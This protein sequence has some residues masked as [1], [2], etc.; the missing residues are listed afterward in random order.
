M[1]SVILPVYNGAKYIQKAIESIISQTYTDWELIIVNDGSTDCTTEKIDA[2]RD[3][4]E[5]VCV[6]NNFNVGVT[7]S[8]NIALKYVSGDYIALQNADDTS[9]PRRFEEQLKL[10]KDNVGIVTTYSTAMN[11]KS[12][13]IADWYTDQAQRSSKDEILKSRK[14]WWVCGPSMMYTKEAIKRIGGYNEK[15]VI[16][17]DYNLWLRIIKHYDFDIVRKELYRFRRHKGSVRTMTKDK[18]PD[19]TQIA[20]DNV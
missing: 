12:K 10:F 3:K 20:L 7:K 1:I 8:L 4:C 14:D 6:A 15:C 17:Q 2:Y 13:T 5:M 9:M 16:A 19:W 18:K 11:A